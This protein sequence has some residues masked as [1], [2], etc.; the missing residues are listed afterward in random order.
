MSPCHLCGKEKPES[1]LELGAHPIAHRFLENPEEKEFVHPVQLCLCSGC[2]LIQLNDPIP[3]KELYTKYNWLSGWKW[4]P[5]VP[6]LLE[7]IGELEGIDTKS[8]ILEVGCND[9]SFLDELRKAGYTNLRGVEPASD[10]RAAARA[11]GL[12]VAD[13]YFSAKTADDIASEHGQCDL[14]I[15]RQ[16]LEH[17]PALADYREGLRRVL[18]PGGWAL[19]EVPDFDLCLDTPDYSAI[20]EEHVNYFTA[21]TL[22]R[23]FADAGIRLEKSET[24]IFS[25]KALIAVGRRTDARLPGRAKAAAGVR[26]RALRY[27]DLW[28]RFRKAFA[29]HLEKHRSG[30]GKAAVYGGGCR[31]SSLINFAGLGPYLEFCVDDQ[32][33]KQGKFMPGSRL[34]ILP[35]EQLERDSVS[36]CLLAVNAENEET[37]IAKR[38]AFSERGG[39]FESVH[40]PS[41]RLP[42]FWGSL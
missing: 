1:L 30:G 32:P 5:H 40:P 16:V 13:A 42:A 29:R 34:R 38:R 28:P 11:K 24:A 7:L 3:P 6:R 37:V 12:A 10:A 21:P 22:G 4:N 31:A 35:G 27:R 8:K 2:G 15:S 39:R 33:E 17:I 18:K 9:G 41:G 14:F 36:L 23:F 20:W 25:G 19:I 26:K